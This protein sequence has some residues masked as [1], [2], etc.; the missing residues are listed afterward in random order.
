MFFKTTTARF[1]ASYTLKKKKKK[2][3]LMSFNSNPTLLRRL[4]LKER[5]KN[6]AK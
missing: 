3:N 4:P 5:V 2:T 6:G 1:C